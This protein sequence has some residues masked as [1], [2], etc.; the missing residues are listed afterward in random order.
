MRK[1][2]CSILVV[3]LPVAALPAKTVTIPFGTTIFCEL[4]QAVTTRQKEAHAVQTGD[5]VQAHVWRDVWID[6]HVVIKAGTSVYAKVDW[7]KK[8]R[9]AGQKGYLVIEVLAAQAVD[10]NDVPV[11]G[12]YDRSGKG[13]MG[14][15][16]GLSVVVAWPFLFIKGKNVF[17]ESGTIFD[18]VVRASTEVE[19]PDSA[20][21]VTVERLPALQVSI[22]YSELNVE[23]KIKKIPLLIQVPE[24]ELSKASIVSING[25]KI[26]P[27]Q[28]ELVGEAEIE[29]GYR[30]IADFR[31]LSKYF[32]GGM[33]RF[34]VEV[35]EERAEVLLEIEF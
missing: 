26:Y 5:V 23:K 18:A 21:A 19:I 24:Q 25:M 3:L 11:D 34:E 14:V 12:G 30:A 17:L 4:D 28:I 33:N 32:T 16:L 9:M 20:P 2:I 35:G 15:T 29:D 22:D 31:I 27:V 1:W 7:M 10:G 13:R 6:G 8:A